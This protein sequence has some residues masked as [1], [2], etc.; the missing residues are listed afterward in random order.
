MPPNPGLSDE[1]AK[2]VVDWI[3]SS[4]RWRSS[5]ESIPRKR[6]ASM[7]SCHRLERPIQTP[8][9]DSDQNGER[10]KESA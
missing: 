8:R 6:I 7:L 4:R 2:P 3:L 1:D 9:I 10:E 5:P